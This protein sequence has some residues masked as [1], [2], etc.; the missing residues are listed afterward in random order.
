[1]FILFSDFN[2]CSI[3]WFLFC[4]DLS[5]SWVELPW[6][7][8][9]ALPLWSVILALSL[10][11]AGPW[12]SCRGWSWAGSELVA[13]RK[14]APWW[15]RFQVIGVLIFTSHM[16]SHSNTE[17][18]PSIRPEGGTVD[19]VSRRSKI[20]LLTL[21]VSSGIPVFWDDSS[22]S[23][24]NLS[25]PAVETNNQSSGCPFGAWQICSTKAW[26]GS[27]WYILAIY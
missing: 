1:M 10:L 15:G 8:V 20:V 11:R 17:A 16:H 14:L 12:P 25:C 3:F 19:W 27:S 2:N 23:F 24:F 26:D 21:L 6:Q 22:F 13:I 9:V 5:P 7:S 4:L 18:L